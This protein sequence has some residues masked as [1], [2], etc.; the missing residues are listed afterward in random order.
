MSFI[1]ESLRL[2]SSF[3]HQKEKYSTKWYWKCHYMKRCLKVLGRTMRRKILGQEI[4][5]YIYMIIII[6]SRCL[7]GSPWPSL[8]TSLY[9]PSLPEGGVQSYI[10]YRHRD[11]VC[12]SWSSCFCSSIW[13]GLQVRIVYEL[14]LTSP[15]VSC[16]IGSSNLDSFHD[17]R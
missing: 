15:A 10:L 2:L 1:S 3:Q 7:H 9:S 5:T 8:A 17:G 14:I 16:M 4:Y 11:F 6:M 13:K 12:S